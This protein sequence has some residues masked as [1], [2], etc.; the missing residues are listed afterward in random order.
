METKDLAL[1]QTAS[2]GKP[3]KSYI[4]TI[5][6][7]VYVTVWNSFENKA[8]GVILYGDP[9]RFDD[10]CIVDIFSPEEDYFFK[11]KNKT[12]LQTG[13]VIEFER[14]EEAPVKTPETFSDAELTEIINKPFFS[15]QK[16]VNDTESTALLFRIKHLAETLEKSEKVMKLI[17]GRISEVQSK[18]FS[19]GPNKVETEL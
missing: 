14:K 19:S 6:G 16:L 13:N 2:A 8:E 3:M 4:K 11:N 9:R 15:I 18:E 12:H 1:L 17:E 5:L 10:E 7:K